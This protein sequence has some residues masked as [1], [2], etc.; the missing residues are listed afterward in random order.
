MKV[1]VTGGR[2]ASHSTARVVWDWLDDLYYCLVTVG[3]GDYCTGGSLQIAQGGAPGVD[4]FARDWCM[5]RGVHFVNYPY[6]S[7]FGRAGGRMRNEVMLQSFRPD[8]VVAFPGGSGTRH[9]KAIAEAAGYPV[10]NM[11]ENV[12]ASSIV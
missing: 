10:F 9:M 8:F 2:H 6:L 4:K 12:N 3:V 5:K 7:E 11:M 1:L